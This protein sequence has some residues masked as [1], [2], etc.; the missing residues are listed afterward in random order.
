MVTGIPAPQDGEGF[1]LCRLLFRP[2]AAVHVPVSVCR[3]VAG[4]GISVSHRQA[5]ALL[6]GPS[7]VLALP[8]GLGSVGPAGASVA[9]LPGP[10]PSVS[11]LRLLQDLGQR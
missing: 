6:P 7:G 8:P 3:S 10:L 11:V 2:A 1:S 9:F 4:P 5:L